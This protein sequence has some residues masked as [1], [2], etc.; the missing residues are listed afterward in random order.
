MI[1]SPELLCPDYTEG[2]ESKFKL[3]FCSSDARWPIFAEQSVT[4][5]PSI[6]VSNTTCSLPAVVKRIACITE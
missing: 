4:G 1:E 5:F 2:C 3:V 6:A